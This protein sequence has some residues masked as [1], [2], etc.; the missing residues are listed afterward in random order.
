METANI[1]YE[2]DFGGAVW[3]DITA[4]VLQDPAPHFEWGMQGV[5]PEDLVADVGVARFALRNS[6]MNSGGL[7][8]YY[9]PG[10]DNCRDGWDD[11]VGIRLRV[12][13]GP[14][15]GT[16]KYGEALYGQ[17]YYK[18]RGK[19][20]SI[21]PAMGRYRERTVE[22]G[23]VDWMDQT[24]QQHIA[25]IGI[26]ISKRVDQLLPYVLA[27]MTI[28]PRATSYASGEETFGRFFDSDN[29]QKMS[30]MSVLQKLAQN[31]IGYIHLDG[32]TN[33]GETL[34]FDSRNTRLLNTTVGFIIDNRMGELEVEYARSNVKNLI[35]MK[36]YPK[37]IDAAATTVL[38]TGQVKFSIAAGAS[39]T[40]IC[41]FRDP[42][43][44]SPISAMDVVNP[45]VADTDYKFGSTEGTANDLNGNLGIVAT[46]G[47]NSAK[48]VLT[49]GAGVTGWVNLLQIRGKGIYSYD[50]QIV[51]SSDDAS[52]L[53]R[54]ELLLDWELR[55]HDNPNVGE[56]MAAYL[57]NLWSLP[58]MLPKSVSV[59]ANIDAAL[60]R[61]LLAAEPSTRFTMLEYMTG[62]HADYHINGITLDIE[63]GGILRFGLA[64]VPA[65]M[66]SYFIWDTSLWDADPWAP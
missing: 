26:Q 34:R 44:G 45:L 42:T 48:L 46:I 5:G 61:G 49:N 18:G 16:V 28:Q 63:P 2:C 57:K 33:G 11:G 38:Y 43:G 30:V 15:Y 1:G 7:E 62:I 36:L 65:D 53:A 58:R 54:G 31:E 20:S 9:S 47:G 23:C 60:M 52:I 55:Q 10:H 3:T 41:P 64:C 56:T 13:R 8:G 27:G 37:K 19:V 51:E 14:L 29:D 4:D 6:A 32:D 22:V 25:Q 17:Q 12:G 24:L 35:R 40:V 39:T 66:T 21:T 50:P 59:I